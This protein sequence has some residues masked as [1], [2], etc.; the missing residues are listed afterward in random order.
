[1]ITVSNID[2]LAFI[3]SL[4]KYSDINLEDEVFIIKR[5]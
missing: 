2:N 3:F 1:M 4:H 5:C